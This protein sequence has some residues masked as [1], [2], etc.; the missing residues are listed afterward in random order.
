MKTKEFT[1][2]LTDEQI[3]LLKDSIKV[4]LRRA[5]EEQ[6][7]LD[8]TNIRGIGKS[9]ALAE[10]AKENGYIMIHHGK[11]FDPKEKYPTMSEHELFQKRGTNE[12][13]GKCLVIDEGVDIKTVREYCDNKIV[14][15][16]YSNSIVSKTIETEDSKTFMENTILNLREEVNLL[17]KKIKRARNLNNDGTYKNLINALSEI[18]RLI[19]K[20]DYQLMYSEYSTDDDKQVAVWEQNNDGIIRNHKIWNVSNRV[21]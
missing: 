7:F 20:Y 5:E 12:I 14:T 15:G 9:T 21:K 10:Y 11:I 18:L 6:C 1:P 3:E 16:F 8:M 17:N 2:F 4:Q 13:R 19:E